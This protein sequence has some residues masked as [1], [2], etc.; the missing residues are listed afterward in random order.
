MKRKI[1]VILLFLTPVL[2]F[3]GHR[4][5]KMVFPPDNLESLKMEIIGALMCGY[6]A[7]L[8][9]WYLDRKVSQKQGEKVSEDLSE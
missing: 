8:G 3:C 1:F 7:S 9:L 5:V 4:L 6:G 2:F